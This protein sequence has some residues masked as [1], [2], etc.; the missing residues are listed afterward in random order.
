MEQI[1]T[2]AIYLPQFHRVKENDEWWGEGYT[3][4][5]AVQQAESYYE[6][7]EQ[8]RIPLNKNYYD[9][10]LKDTMKWQAE[11]AQEYGVHGFC[12]FHYYT[13]HHHN[14]ENANGINQ[15]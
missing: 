1:K 15:F 8:P 13:R 11:L 4:W 7:H 10:S 12:F 2:I 5:A 6:G 3:E 9:L 14:E